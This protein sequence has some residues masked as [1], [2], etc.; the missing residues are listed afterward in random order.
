MHGRW[1]DGFSLLLLLFFFHV[2]QVTPVKFKSI[3][4]FLLSF[5]SKDAQTV[6]LVGKLCQRFAE[7]MDEQQWRDIAY[8]L[9]QLPYNVRCLR[10]IIEGFQFYKVQMQDD[11]VYDC[12]TVIVGKARKTNAKK[13]EV[14]DEL[15]EWAT[16]LERLNQGLNEE[17]SSEGAAV[18]EEADAAKETGDNDGEEEESEDEDVGMLDVSDDDE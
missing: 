10:K 12:F 8:C 15:E 11:S 17:A 6:A 9:T 7:S 14:H 1:C 18:G 3:F 5:I 16:K 2:L 13:P 4:K